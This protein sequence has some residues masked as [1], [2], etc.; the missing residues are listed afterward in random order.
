MSSWKARGKSAARSALLPENS[1]TNP[2]V[3][4]LWASLLGG[5]QPPPNSRNTALCL[6]IWVW[7]MA[8]WKHNNEWEMDTPGPCC[9]P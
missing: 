9:S 3:L 5:C 6:P 4:W 1:F 8:W 2:A 7:V